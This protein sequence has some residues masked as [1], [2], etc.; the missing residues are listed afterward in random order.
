MDKQQE[1]NRRLFEEWFNNRYSWKI[2]PSMRTASSYTNNSR[3]AGMWE[4]WKASRASIVVEL[5]DL[6]RYYAGKA[7]HTRVYSA[8]AF[9]N[10]VE[11][12]LRSIGLSI[13]GE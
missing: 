6:E 9:R 5:P 3:A 2:S 1:E 10:D 13:K 7:A 12:N 8:H 4:A 11:K